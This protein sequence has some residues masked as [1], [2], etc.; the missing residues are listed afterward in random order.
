MTA[1]A[2][3]LSR[4]QTARTILPMAALAAVVV[5]F[6]GGWRGGETLSDGAGM[7]SVLGLAF[8]H[9]RDGGLPYWL[10]EIWGGTPAWALGPSF[11][12]TWM[13]PLAQVLGPEGAVKYG[14]LAAQVAGAWGAFVFARSLWGGTAAPLLAG[15]IYGLSPMAIGHAALYGIEPVI[16]VIAAVPWFAWTFRNALVHPGLRWPVAS[17]AIATFAL[18]QQA[19]YAYPYA[20]LGLAFV[21]VEVNRRRARGGEGMGPMLGRAAAATL[22]A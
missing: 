14:G 1:T 8:G 11:T 19:E 3:P 9:F 12:L 13:F 5:G 7:R 17:G 10:D 18:L 16:W 6:A 4:P 2:P 21:V 20:I 22:I 15:L